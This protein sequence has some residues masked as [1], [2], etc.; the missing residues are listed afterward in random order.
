MELR[1]RLEEP[2]TCG[3]DLWSFAGFD[4]SFDGLRQSEQLRTWR[5]S[6]RNG[7]VALLKLSESS[8]PRW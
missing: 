2:L 7:P 1:Q 5:Q 8:F 4:S 6:K 3:A